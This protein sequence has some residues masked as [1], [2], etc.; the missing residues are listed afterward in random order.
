MIMGEREITFLK[1]V[2]LLFFF[3]E[4]M[5]SKEVL[6]PGI[7]MQTFEFLNFCCQRVGLSAWKGVIWSYFQVSI[8]TS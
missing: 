8:S 1:G 7:W 5:N 3:C 2:L 4:G 6:N